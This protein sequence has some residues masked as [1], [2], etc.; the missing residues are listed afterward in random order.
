VWRAGASEGGGA[1]TGSPAAPHC[2]ARLGNWLT[3]EQASDLLTASSA[4]ESLRARALLCLL[5]GCGLGRAEAAALE[6]AQEREGR[7]VLADILGKRGRIRTAPMPSWAKVAVDQWTE[8]SGVRE[9]KLFRAVQAAGKL[10]IRSAWRFLT[11]HPRSPHG[12]AGRRRPRTRRAITAGEFGGRETKAVVGEGG[13][14]EAAQQRDWRGGRA[15]RRRR[16]RARRVTPCQR[17]SIWVL[18]NRE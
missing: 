17:E 12:H 13:R 15:R 10:T 16:Q 14:P 11:R 8:A 18:V 5:V 6:V 2:G 9:G 3:R 7:W 1:E 4:G